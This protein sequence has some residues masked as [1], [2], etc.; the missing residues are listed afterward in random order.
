M[1]IIYC[2]PLHRS[3]TD[4]INNGAAY[5]RLQPLEFKLKWAIEAPDKTLIPFYR[6]GPTKYAAVTFIIWPHRTRGAV[7]MKILLGLLD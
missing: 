1:D 5:T 7:L 3:K 4:I 6:P 2:T